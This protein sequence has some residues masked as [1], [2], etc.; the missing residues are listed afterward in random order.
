[1]PDVD[2]AVDEDWSL[3]A[4]VGILAAGLEIDPRVAANRQVCHKRYLEGDLPVV[5]PEVVAAFP[6]WRLGDEVA[7]EAE[8]EP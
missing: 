1:M 3:G 8:A 4:E 7:A 2:S 6:V 5:G